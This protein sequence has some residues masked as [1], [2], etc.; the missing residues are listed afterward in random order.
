MDFTT[1][2]ALN[3]QAMANMHMQNHMDMMNMHMNAVRMM[4][5]HSRPAVVQSRP[6]SVVN[7]TTADDFLVRL[8]RNG[9]DR[10]FLDRIDYLG[11]SNMLRTVKELCGAASTRRQQIEIC[12]A[13]MKESI[14]RANALKH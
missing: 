7:D 9:F 5:K 2:A 12:K 4:R 6:R 3:H 8:M 14:R 13:F 1:Q 10:E 11:M